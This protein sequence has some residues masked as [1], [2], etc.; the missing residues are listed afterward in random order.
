MRKIM[1]VGD[2]HGRTV[3]KEFADIKFLLYAEPESAGFGGFVPEYQRYVFLGDYCDSFDV[4]SDQIRENLLELIRFKTLYPNHVVLL[5][6]NHDVEYYL[7]EPWKAMK[8]AVSG[9]RPEAHFDLYDIFNT[10]KD[11]F[12]L[13]YGEG[14]HLFCHSGVHYGWYWYVFTKAIK[15]MGMN[16]MTIAEQ[17]NE[18][19]RYKVECLF[20]VDWYRGG[21]KKVGG[22]LWCDKKLLNK[23]LKNVHQY[24]GHNPV[25]DIHTNNIGDSSITFCDVLH[26]K[27]AFYTL[28][29]P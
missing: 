8:T 13:A 29:I 12:Q 21:H 5:W 17:L 23:I 20:D 26:H 10:N 4:T 3:W 1:V 28:I 18:A 2:I 14:N 11:L 27:K 22:P 9:F 24:C 19:F 15:D 25:S 6:G 16:D 7:N